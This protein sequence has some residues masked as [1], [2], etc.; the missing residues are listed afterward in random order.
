MG[1]PLS[2]GSFQVVRM[3]RLAS[4]AHVATAVSVGP[5]Q[6]IPLKS[7]SRRNLHCL[8]QERNSVCIKSKLCV[9]VFVASHLH[10]P[11]VGVINAHLSVFKGEACV[12]KQ[13]S[14]AS[15]AL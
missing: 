13:S 4:G 6:L 8:A 14:C 12:H 7:S 11:V 15:D 1:Y 2:F 10:D 3:Q 5:K 9:C